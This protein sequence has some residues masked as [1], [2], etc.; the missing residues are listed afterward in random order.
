MT[1][2]KT[3]ENCT[4]AGTETAIR[5][6]RGKPTAMPRESPLHSKNIILGSEC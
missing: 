2:L 5:K 6:P 1:F 4:S 3:F